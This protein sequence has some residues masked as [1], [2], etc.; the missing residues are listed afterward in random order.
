MEGVSVGEEQA[1]RELA[2]RASETVRRETR[3]LIDEREGAFIEFKESARWSHIAGDKDK[4]SELEVLRTVAGFMNAKGGSLLIGVADDATVV[5]LAKD[6]KSL[7]KRP[8]SDGFGNW[9]TT[10]VIRLHLGAAVLS[11]LA[12]RFEDVD[13]IESVGSMLSRAPSPSM[14]MARGSSCESTTQRRNWGSLTQ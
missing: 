13:G 1:E 4:E 8:D 6:Y 12:I 2:K 9:L 3:A 14:S 11:H 7:Q 5:G 10:D